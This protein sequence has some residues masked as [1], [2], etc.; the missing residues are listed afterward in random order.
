MKIMVI[1]ILRVAVGLALVWVGLSWAVLSMVPID[2]GETFGWRSLGVFT[3]VVA[4]I[5]FMS[6]LISG[7]YLLVPALLLSTV[8]WLL[9]INVLQ[10]PEI[11]GGTG[12]FMSGVIERAPQVLWCNACLALGISMGYRLARRWKWVA[13]ARN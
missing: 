7:R 3:L 8:G 5:G 9:L 12:T 11:K 10:W 2:E 4:A 6:G 1:A 13:P